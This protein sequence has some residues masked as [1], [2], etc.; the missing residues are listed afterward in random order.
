LAYDSD[1]SGN[2]VKIPGVPGKF[3]DC[4]KDSEKSDSLLILV[5][6][7]L[8]IDYQTAVLE[9]YKK[10]KA[11]GDLSHRMLHQGPAKLRDECVTVYKQRYDRKD[12]K[13]LADF[14]DP[15]SE[16]DWLKTIR[17]CDINK[18]KPI[19]NFMNGKTQKPDPKIVEVLA[20]LIDFKPRPWEEAEK[21]Y[22]DSTHIPDLIQGESPKDENEKEGEERLPEEPGQKGKEG[23]P[24]PAISTRPAS[25]SKARKAI[26][27]AIMGVA[28]FIVI[29]WGWFKAPAI[30]ST[31]PQGCMY[32][33]GDHYQ[34]VSCNQKI[35]GAMV[36]ALDSEKLDHF[37]RITR[38][39]TITENSITK[40]WCVKVSGNYE[41]YTSD[42]FHPIDHRLRLRPLSAYIFRNH[43]RSGQ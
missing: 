23:V 41:Y 39:D 25:G 26:I 24:A 21:K 5:E 1:N 30:I 16:K 28:V 8:F 18:F 42:G 43:P 27:A 3:R 13:T 31:G 35:D 14:F 10:K 7:I 38:P 36:I 22:S 12:D 2:S 11:A 37:K 34:Q 40:I 19:M 32:W 33:T 29:Y 15:G 9:K 4:G 6:M 17:Q 20:W